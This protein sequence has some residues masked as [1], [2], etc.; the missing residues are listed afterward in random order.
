MTLGIGVSVVRFHHQ[1]THSFC[2][3]SFLWLYFGDIRGTLHDLPDS[4]SYGR[5]GHNRMDGLVEHV[6]SNDGLGYAAY[7]GSK[8][9]IGSWGGMRW[10]VM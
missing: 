2:F 4:H 3:D 7:C 8:S 6:W 10:Y 1:G 9:A 5:C